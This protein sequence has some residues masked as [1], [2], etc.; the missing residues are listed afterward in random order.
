MECARSQP[1]M[2]QNI[3]EVDRASAGFF[4]RGWQG[5]GGDMLKKKRRLTD[6]RKKRKMWGLEDLALLGGGGR[7]RTD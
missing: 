3:G 5:A 2:W 6:N 4:R 7:G 1:T